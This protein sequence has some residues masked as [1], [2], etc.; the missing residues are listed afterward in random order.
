MRLTD[1]DK[2]WLQKCHPGLRLSP[3]GIAGSVN[4]V[5]TYN[6]ET[7]L[8]QILYNGSPDQVGGVRLRM[9]FS[10]RLEERADT[11][12]SRLPALYVDGVETITDRHFAQTDHTGCL[13][14][15]LEEDGFLVDGLDFVPFFEQL[16]IP[17]LYG[18]K[19]Y[20]R[21]G[22]WPWAEYA[23]G[24]A[25]LL[26]AY[27]KMADPS[28]A[29]ECFRY[30]LHDKRAVRRIAALVQQLSE[31]NDHT[32]CFC[33]RSDH[34]RRCH[35]EALQGLRQLRRHLNAQRQ[36]FASKIGAALPQPDEENK[37]DRAGENQNRRKNQI[38][39]VARDLNRCE[40]PGDFKLT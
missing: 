22:T 36:W 34:I 24:A 9:S 14:S 39:L 15:P 12:T 27:A 40:K 32:P 19:F 13:C 37:C 38:T 18:Q 31:I 33:Q 10:I 3:D 8:F 20:S 17:F 35:P 16:V 5:A 11:S 1:S 28:R 21:T 29:E 6:R 26:E 23:H 7:N 30:L 25:G 4:T 2:R